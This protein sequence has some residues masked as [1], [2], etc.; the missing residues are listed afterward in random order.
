MSDTSIKLG[1]DQQ[2]V[3]YGFGLQFGQQ[4]LR[5][6]FEGL[7]V[8][9]VAAGIKDIL[10]ENAIQVSEEEL[11]SAYSTV[12]EVMQAEQT[13]K[14][15]Q[16]IELGKTFLAENAKR[17][18]VTTTASGLQYEI[19]EAGTGA[20]PTAEASVSVHYHGTFMDG[21]V[22]DSS[23]ERGQPAEFGVTQVISGWTEAL[24]LMPKGSKWRLVI[25]SELAY[26]DAGAPPSIP[27]GAVLVFEVHL[28]DIV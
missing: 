11:N 6:N 28:L 2:K 22:F 23:V 1:S 20:T 16:M 3:S 12:Q 10:Q 5:N 8:D 26:G 15:Q 19:L 7:D 21:S 17:D 24:Q 4:L 27:G 13:R 9:A 14:A 25:P 18:G